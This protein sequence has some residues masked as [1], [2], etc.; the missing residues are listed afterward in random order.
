VF[1]RPILFLACLS[2][3]TMACAAEKRQ[4]SAEELRWASDYSW[5]RANAVR[6]HRL[7][8]L[9]V[10]TDW[11]TWCRIMDEDVY[12]SPVV[13]S[14]LSQGYIC[15]RENAESDPEG[16]ALQHKFRVA[17]YPASVV[18]EP[19]DE[20]YVTIYGYRDA[21]QLL[22]AIEAASG[23]LRQLQVVEDNVRDG[24]AT[25]SERKQLAQA[26]AD[27]GFYDKAAREY[28]ALLQ[29]PTVNFLPEE[30]FRAAVSLASAGDN[31]EALGAIGDL[32]KSFP[33]SEVAPEAEALRGEI[34]WHEGETATATQVLKRWL[35]QYP[36]NPLADHVRAV[37]TEIEGAH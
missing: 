13:V 25:T 4:G 31:R 23:E 21:Q 22:N 12:P 14:A 30:E 19:T 36:R 33:G 11:C 24:T 5:A 26:L 15:V 2:A 6:Q 27:R 9:D 10:E 8:I 20:L 17:T 3:L 34:L 37:L 28:L 35:A 29:D 7:L 1:A 16:I 32:E 18:V